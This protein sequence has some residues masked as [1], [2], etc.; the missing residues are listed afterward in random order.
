MENAIFCKKFRLDFF[1]QE[2]QLKMTILSTR[3][4][5]VYV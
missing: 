1:L 3:K 5:E 2:I 4:I